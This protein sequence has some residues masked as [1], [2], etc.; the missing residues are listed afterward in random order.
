MF[1]ENKSESPPD[2]EFRCVWSPL[3]LSEKIRSNSSVLEIIPRAQRSGFKRAIL[4]WFAKLE[5]KEFDNSLLRAG[6]LLGTLLRYSLN[7]HLK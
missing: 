7:T 2:I 6:K 5:K 4:F 3:E 1:L